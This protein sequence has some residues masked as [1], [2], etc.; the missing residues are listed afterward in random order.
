MAPSSRPIAS[1]KSTTGAA[2]AKA[3]SKLAS[4]P[5]HELDAY[6]ADL[7][8]QK[9][10]AKEDN[11]KQGDYSDDEEATAG[12]SGPRVPNTNKR[13]LASVIRNVDGH[14]QALLRQQA[15]EARQEA[16]D[17]RSHD[18]SQRETGTGSIRKKL[19]S[20][21]LRGWSDDEE[22]A[23]DYDRLSR[24]SSVASDRTSSRR[25][26]SPE[27]SSKMDKY[28]NRS[29]SA[30]GAKVAEH[31]SNEDHDRRHRDGHRSHSRREDRHDGTSGS[32][33]K[34]SREKDRK[35][36]SRRSERSGSSKDKDRGHRSSKSRSSSH[37]EG[38]HSHRSDRDDNERHS[39]RRHREDRP[40]RDG[41]LRRHSP[42]KRKDHDE[43]PR[44]RRKVGSS[45]DD[46]PRSR[47]KSSSDPAK[48]AQS[49]P[50]KKVREWDL[51]KES[52]AF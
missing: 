36:S 15:R 30:K 31:F 16:G 34:R 12:S 7:I 40:D 14:N 26:R 29:E 3:E 10:R 46:R 21:K 13:F 19:T 9:A 11:T 2:E 44:E 39:S 27:L 47:R 43:G 50:P 42:G 48:P 32:S 41:E 1:A 51:G 22:D 20:S 24:A 25:S 52:L 45:H 18:S 5:D 8:V 6:I 4:I 23:P 17:E 37:R 49:P 35:A 33:S 28:F 38:E